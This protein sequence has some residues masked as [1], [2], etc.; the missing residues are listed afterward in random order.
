MAAA[1]ERKPIGTSIW[2]TYP[3]FL[4]CQNEHLLKFYETGYRAD[5]RRLS[6]HGFFEC[7]QCQPSTY[8]LAVFS[9]SPDPHTT[10]YAL[11][12]ESFE[13]WDKNPEPTPPTPELLYLIRDP[14]GRSYNPYWNGPR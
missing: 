13:Q 12:R 11:S 9:T 7:R 4:V 14:A 10:C 8:F 1:P 6:G 5:M 3:N 2:H